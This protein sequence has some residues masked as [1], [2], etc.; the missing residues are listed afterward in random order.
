MVL[1]LD[2]KEGKDPAE[3]YFRWLIRSSSSV[4]TNEEFDL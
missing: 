1:K 2:Q 4:H 3:N